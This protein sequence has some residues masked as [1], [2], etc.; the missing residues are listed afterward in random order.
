MVG[1]QLDDQFGTI[2]GLIDPSGKNLNLNVSSNKN[3]LKEEPVGN[4]LVRAL[5]IAHDLATKE[6]KLDALVE[7]A[8]EPFKKETG[9]ILTDKNLE[10]GVLSKITGGQFKSS[11]GFI[12]KRE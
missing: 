12:E 5:D 1:T 9:M 3:L 6:N 7:A 11:G 4:G 10:R 8:K 2:K